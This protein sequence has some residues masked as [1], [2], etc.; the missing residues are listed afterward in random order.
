MIL[1]Q[2]EGNGQTV[3]SGCLAKGIQPMN[4]TSMLTA[5]YYNG[6]SLIGIYCSDCLAE[7][8]KYKFI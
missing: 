5:V 2:C 3:C 7:I 6:G 1:K 8:K 4:W